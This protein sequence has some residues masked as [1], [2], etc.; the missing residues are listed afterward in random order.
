MA[1]ATMQNKH[2]SWSYM[3][4]NCDNA[5]HLYRHL[6]LIL[7]VFR[8]FL[9]YITF[10]YY[11][12]M[13]KASYRFAFVSAAATYG[14]VVYKAYIARGRLGGSIPATAMKLAGD[15]NVQYLSQWAP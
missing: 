1:F 6:T 14:I 15:E 8:Y 13:A 10:N 12:G 5:T 11:S 9:S 7:A 4:A 3:L 2:T